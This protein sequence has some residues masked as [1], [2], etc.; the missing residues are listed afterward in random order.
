MENTS[1][2]G[3]R[4]KETVMAIKAAFEGP[5]NKTLTFVILNTQEVY[6]LYVHMLDWSG[7][8]CAFP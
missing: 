8:K 3:L 6:I 4:H 5:M 1:L 7:S 2:Y